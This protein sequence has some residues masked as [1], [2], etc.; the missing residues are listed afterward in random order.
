M[1]LLLKKEKPQLNR[2]H[3]MGVLCLPRQV[4]SELE[5]FVI[6]EESFDIR[7]LELGGRGRGGGVEELKCGIQEEHE[8]LCVS[9]T[10]FMLPKTQIMTH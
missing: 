2:A 5:G 3:C 10:K 8:S 1:F 7:V 9:P 4:R 6:L